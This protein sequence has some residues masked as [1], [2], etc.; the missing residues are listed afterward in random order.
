MRHKQCFVAFSFL[1]FLTSGQAH[2]QQSYQ[3]DSPTTRNRVAG[4]QSKVF[5]IG[6]AMRKQA[7]GLERIQFGTR[8]NSANHNLQNRRLEVPYDSRFTGRIPATPKPNF[9]AP[10]Q[11]Y[12]S[13]ITKDC[14]PSVAEQPRVIAKPPK[15]I[16]NP[17]D[18]C[19]SA[20]EGD[21]PRVIA[22]PPVADD[23][24][25]VVPKP[26]ATDYCPPVTAKPPSPVYPDCPPSVADDYRRPVPRPQSE[27]PQVCRCP[28]CGSV[29]GV[30]LL[31][32]KTATRSSATV[33]TRSLD[34]QQDF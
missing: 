14:P 17:K 23:Y 21:R 8:P 33:S 3:S 18:E 10:A 28:N 11:D 13:V 1:I 15:Q 4:N 29:L 9:S 26:P 34:Q 27:Q 5:G 12:P 16:S 31:Q 19:P 30:I 6:T 7:P 20:D 24:P 2:A 25:R 32:P 22:K